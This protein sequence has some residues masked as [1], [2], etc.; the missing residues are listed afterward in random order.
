MSFG[1][2]GRCHGA[3]SARA[4]A[5]S[6]CGRPLEAQ[7]LPGTQDMIAVWRGRARDN[8]EPRSASWGRQASGQP[9]DRAVSETLFVRHRA[10]GSRSVS[11]SFTSAAGP[12]P[13]VPIPAAGQR[14]EPVKCGTNAGG[15]LRGDG[16]A[17]G[18]ATSALCRADAAGGPEP[19]T[20]RSVDRALEGR[21]GPASG[22]GPGTRPAG[23]RREQRHVACRDRPVGRPW[24]PC[25][26]RRRF[27]G[28][29]APP[30]AAPRA[31]NRH[32]SGTSAVRMLWSSG[33]GRCLAAQEG[34][35]PPASQPADLR[36]GNS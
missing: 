20:D 7:A 32:R 33:G 22:A 23:S 31:A 35:P 17:A 27:R 4:R 28:A 11:R 1:D 16:G 14:R 19:A 25:R 3:S 2:Q 9:L 15:G 29:Q 8:V 24:R 26:S 5:R 30:C 13:A 12:A 6:G 10:P 21:G 36:V 34:R 18:G